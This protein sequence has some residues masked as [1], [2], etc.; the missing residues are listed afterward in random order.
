MIS[1]ITEVN[2]PLA[3]YT[4]ITYRNSGVVTLSGNHTSPRCEK[5]NLKMMGHACHLRKHKDSSDFMNIIHPPGD[6]KTP[7]PYPTLFFKAQILK[8]LHRVGDLMSKIMVEPHTRINRFFSSAQVKTD[9]I[10]ELNGSIPAY[11]DE[12]NLHGLISEAADR[13]Q[14]RTAV[15][16]K[17]ST[18]SYKELD[19]KSNQLAHALIA[20]GI[21]KNHKI[22]LAVD[23][24]P[25]MI[26]A[27]L[28]I[29]KTGA[30]FVPIDPEY[31]LARIQYILK[32]VS[33]ELIILSEKYTDNHTKVS[34]QI[35][36]E[37][38]LSNLNEYP[39]T[40]VGFEVESTDL[41]YIL[42]TSGSTGEPKG[43]EIRHQSVVNIFFWLL[44]ALRITP[45]DKLLALTSVSFD[46]AYVELLAPL[47]VG[48]EIILTDSE[49][50]RDG[51]LILELMEMEHITVMQA[52]PSFWRMILNSGWTKKY[53][54]KII[55][56]G[57][58][59]S[60]NLAQRLLNN[61]AE[62]WNNYGPTETTIYSTGKR[63]N[64]TDELITIG[65]PINNTKI[66]ILDKHRQ[67]VNEGE[68]GEVYIAGVG[69]S[70]GYHNKPELTDQRF[71]PDIL[72]KS[73]HLYSTGDLGRIL[74]NGELQ[75]LGRSDQQIKIRGFRIEPQEIEHHFLG[76]S[77]VK[78]I[79]IEAV[80]KGEESILVAFVILKKGGAEHINSWK[81]TV[82][83]ALPRYMIPQKFICLESFPTTPNGK[84]DRNA[85]EVIANQ[86]LSPSRGFTAP[87]TK[88]QK[89]LAEIWMKLLKVKKV[90]MSDNF[91]DLGG[92]S[93]I[94]VSL[95]VR[96]EK[97]TGRR[98]P[99]ATLFQNPTIEELAK[100]IER[101]DSKIEW[102]SLVPLKT[103]GTKAPLYFIHG[104]GLNVF[105]LHAIID[106]LDNDRPFYGMQ[107]IG[108]DG[109][110]FEIASMEA[111]ASIY[112]AELL[113]NDPD[114]PYALMGY[115]LGGNIALEMAK[116]L[117]AAGKKVAFLGMLDT[118]IDQV[119]LLDSR[120][121][122][123]TKK[124]RRQFPKF[125]FIVKSFWKYPVDTIKYQLAIARF[126]FLD[127]FGYKIKMI[128]KEQ[129]FQNSIY[130]K[131]QLAHHHHKITPYD[132]VIHLFKVQKRLYF[133]DDDKY[134]GWKP[135]APAGLR[136]YEVPGDHK[137]CL[138]APHN[139]KFVEILEKALAEAEK[140]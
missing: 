60:K 7:G 122:Q 8:N 52:T 107:A 44:K 36:F 123:L 5:I 134:M 137:T 101:E 41:I 135:F 47:L 140:G 54:I 102:K 6:P 17:D 124:I 42:H 111:I 3:L 93:L 62:L 99:I 88:E 77:E 70:A 66:Y 29:M 57:E 78:D 39:T 28:G 83:K 97:A 84:M 27:L 82:S 40:Q 125:I 58:P 121:A 114:G 131:Y 130:E 43:V 105:M 72:D 33:A 85:L 4:G 30:V 106:R 12:K 25:E 74:Q 13:Y 75:L 9:D 104:A 138:L 50:A 108:L 22:G 95:M 67:K 110:D 69:L 71:F 19:E 56:G 64:S 53:T 2:L 128:S 92:H 59:L 14:N 136:I 37:D 87:T 139:E 112:V 126:K 113:A 79:V 63:I 48:A 96:I 109:S 80:S 133:L 10:D 61:C 1:R 127:I 24:C 117:K 81:T 120:F 129:S 94:A 90:S 89:L 21:K 35:Y 15:R 49:T 65:K 16:F 34:R 26:I 73:T 55:S 32:D 31:P 86:F 68:T 118:Y 91:F 115:S 100:L 46:I 38:L 116:Q 20:Q 23:R 76:I 51:R 45:S 103:N 18:I 98:L 11:P 132:D 119:K